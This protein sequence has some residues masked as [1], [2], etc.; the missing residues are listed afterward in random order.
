MARSDSAQPDHPLKRWRY[1]Q[2]P[3]ITAAQL[4]DLIGVTRF[5]VSDYETR[6]R[7]PR[8]S[9]FLKIKEVTGGALCEADFDDLV[10]AG[11]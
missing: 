11:A 4:G 6:R 5:T 8:R 2:K 1:S 3:P 9:V 7:R 10:G